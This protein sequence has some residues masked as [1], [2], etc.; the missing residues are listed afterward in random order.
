MKISYKTF[1]HI[2]FY[3][4]HYKDTLDFY[5]AGLGFSKA[6]DLKDEHGILRLTYLKIN[7]RQF[8]ELFPKGYISDNDK[9]L[10][11]LREFVIYVREP[12]K[13]EERLKRRNDWY[14]EIGGAPKGIHTVDPEGNDILIFKEPGL[15]DD[16]QLMKGILNCKDVGKMSAFYGKCLDAV[17]YLEFVGGRGDFQGRGDSYRHVCIVVNDILQ[18]AC[19]LESRGVHIKTG[20]AKCI[21]PYVFRPDPQKAGTFM[22]YDPEGNEIEFMQYREE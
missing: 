14:E 19:E 1:G 11:A 4:N 13:I 8:I 2:C 12:E 15:I 7:E 18:T 10:R 16:I 3:C 21:N 17:N 6:C 20:T 9:K 22:V 5:E